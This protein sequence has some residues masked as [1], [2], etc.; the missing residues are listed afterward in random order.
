MLRTLTISTPGRICLFGEHQDYL[1]LP[2]IAAAI[3]LRMRISGAPR[4]DLRFQIELPDIRQRLDF[5]P[6]G[7]LAYRLER[8][9]FRSGF[10]VV[11]ERGFRPQHGWQCEVRGEVPI[12]SGTSSSSALMV[13]WI[14]FLLTAAHDPQ[15]NDCEVIARLAYQA[16]VREFNEPGGMMDHFSTCYGHV[17]YLDFSNNEVESLKPKLGAFV[18]GDSQQ[19]K[20]TKNILR[21]VRD[22]AQAA[23]NMMRSFLPQFDLRQTLL[24]EAKD[25]LKKLPPRHAEVLR[26]NLIDRDLLREAHLVLQQEPLDHSRLGDLLNQHHEQLRR[27][28]KVSTP[29]IEHMLENAMKAG[30]LGGKI[31]GSGGGGCMFAYAPQHSEVVAEAIREAGGVPYLVSIDAGARLEVNNENS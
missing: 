13:A 23:A 11:W 8:D 30:A 6:H 16:E 4:A 15:Q 2:V 29:K 21:N 14:K 24:E 7:R 20:D 28:K 10:N 31:N 19:P 17:I 1:G 12:N 27:Y 9:Y 25:A 5:I 22:V 18:L 3:S 26:A